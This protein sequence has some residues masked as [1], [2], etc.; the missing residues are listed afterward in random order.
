MT[1]INI[2]IIENQQKI[3]IIGKNV[4][5]N[6]NEFDQSTRNNIKLLFILLHFKNV[7]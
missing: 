4:F 5:F 3:F 1:V 7:L 6:M 2:F